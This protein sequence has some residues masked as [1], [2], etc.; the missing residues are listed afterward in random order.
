[1][2]ETGRRR[3]MLGE[4]AGAA[5]RT[6]GIAIAAILLVA[7]VGISSPAFLT[8]T[9]LLNLLAQWAPAGV[10]AVGMTYV[11]LSGGFDLSIAAGY[12]LCAVTAA[13]LAQNGTPVALAFLA[14]IGVGLAIGLV[15]A[16]LVA[17]VGI[18]PFITTVGTGFIVNGIAL[19]ATGNVSYVVN[20]PEFAT[21]GTG[22]WLD[23]P[24]IGLVLIAF[25]VIGGIVLAKTVYG[26]S[27]Y[28]VG[29]NEEASR[30]AGIRVKTVVG[31]SYVVSG[32]C[33]GVAGVMSASQLSSAQPNLN[34]NIVFDVITI[35][36]VGGTSL[37]GGIGAMWRTAV[38]LVIIA[39]ISNAF[40]LLDVDP[41]W[42]DV[43]KGLIIVGALALDVWA[44]RFSGRRTA[45][46]TQ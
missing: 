17:L 11:I 13:G 24:Y 31:S 3:R 10:M 20:D 22:R 38:G 7:A 21:F 5:M 30:L 40:N 9:N 25:L 41:N 2:T 45:L 36:V 26:Q 8:S 37:A 42:Q 4:F 27:I 33:V 1:M 23:I 35:V 14:A 44:N 39:T 18:N 12:S 32:L 15:N 43:V 16:V 6:Y 28:A 34:A 46:N 19:V 29:G